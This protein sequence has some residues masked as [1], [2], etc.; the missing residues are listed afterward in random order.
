MIFDAKKCFLGK[1]TFFFN[2]GGFFYFLFLRQD[3]FLASRIFFL[4][5]RIVF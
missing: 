3:F 1:V 4:A 2:A 5:T